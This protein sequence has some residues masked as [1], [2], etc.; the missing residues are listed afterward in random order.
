[1]NSGS[2]AKHVWAALV[3][4]FALSGLGYWAYST[5]KQAQARG[6][7]L[8]VVG[9]LTR[10]FSDSIDINL[11]SHTI[12]AREQVERLEQNRGDLARKVALLDGQ[13]SEAGP[14]AV[15]DVSDASDASDALD[16]R[17]Y[18]GAGQALMGTLREVAD[19]EMRLERHSSKSKLTIAG[20]PGLVP[21]ERAAA[22]GEVREAL[23]EWGVTAKELERFSRTACAAAAR[24]REERDRFAR[25]AGAA[26]LVE[27]AQLEALRAKYCIPV[28][29]E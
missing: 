20:M 3:L 2:R 23:H 21:A 7:L 25:L 24:F 8:A 13:G 14:G 19:M 29:S 1:M 6:H 16:A 17:A 5:F 4:A 22:I 26:V 12:T 18:V 28:T 11:S 27:P 10:E 9:Q 15:S